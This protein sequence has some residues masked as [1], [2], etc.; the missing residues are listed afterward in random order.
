VKALGKRATVP[1]FIYALKSLTMTVGQI[2][3][4]F[5]LH[6]RL[7]S[8]LASALNDIFRAVVEAT[9]AIKQQKRR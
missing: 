5:C 6:C 8:R 4:F 7:F 9:P 3:N 2:E 1:D